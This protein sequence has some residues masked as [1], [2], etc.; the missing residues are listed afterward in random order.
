MRSYAS[1]LAVLSAVLL[2]TQT[3]GLIYTTTLGVGQY[4]VSTL[5]DIPLIPVT[6]P[7][8]SRFSW[9]RIYPASPVSSFSLLGCAI[10]LI[11]MLIINELLGREH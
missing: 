4:L 7:I 3:S 10:D 9:T 1:V 5:W 8:S 6:A 2:A 11:Y